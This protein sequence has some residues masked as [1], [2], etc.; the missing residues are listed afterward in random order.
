[1]Q[2]SIYCLSSKLYHWGHA[3]V[4]T[5]VGLA[6]KRAI[7][8]K[9]EVSSTGSVQW[10]QDGGSKLIVCLVGIIMLTPNS[11][12]I[13]EWGPSIN[14]VASFPNFLTPPIPRQFLN[15]YLSTHPYPTTFSNISKFVLFNWSNPKKIL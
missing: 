4:H 3:N 14:K 13:S 15:T 7:F 1:M 12:Y 5:T 10:R 9:V 2:K 8:N 6:D 11:S